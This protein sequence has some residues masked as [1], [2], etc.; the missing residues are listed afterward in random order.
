MQD[1][2]PEPLS[3]AMSDQHR[4]SPWPPWPSSWKPGR[5]VRSAKGVV[6]ATTVFTKSAVSAQPPKMESCVSAGV[7]GRENKR[8]WEG[9]WEKDLNQE[10]SWTRLERGLQLKGLQGTQVKRISRYTFHI[11]HPG[12]FFICTKKHVALLVYFSS[13]QFWARIAGR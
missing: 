2:E 5:M 6:P 11:K 3:W 4:S 9:G 8:G 12:T 1:P 13:L 7:P 10:R